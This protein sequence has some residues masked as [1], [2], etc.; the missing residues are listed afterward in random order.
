MT[1][2][3]IGLKDACPE[4]N[5]IQKT[6]GDIRYVDNISTI[7][8]ANESSL[9]WARSIDAKT[10][11]ALNNTKASHAI[12]P[13]GLDM[14]LL[15]N[16]R[17]TIL[18]S[19]YPKLHFSKLANKYFVN[20][21]IPIVHKTASI[22]KHAVMGDDVSIGAN[23]VIGKCMIGRNVVI[24]PNVSINN[25]VVIENNVRIGAGTVIGYDG[26]GYTREDDGRAVKFPH[27]GAVVIEDDVEIG[28]NVCIDRGGLMDTVLKK[29][30]KIDNLVHIAHNVIIGENA[31]VIA[32]AMVAGSVEIGRNTW[33]GPSAS[34]M[35]NT[36]IGNN[37]LVG[38]GAVTLKDIP[39]NEIWA[40]VPAK[41]L[42]DVK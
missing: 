40:G 28:N 11:E 3:T 12:V 26:F 38:M 21:E 2:T 34:I 32:G 33:I 25:N 20:V 30:C 13:E 10:I 41:K 27:V 5:V 19:N 4:L 7:E 8:D 35:N 18:S 36:E 16:K 9:V 23:T 17:I 29:G 37:V 14:K 6:K 15:S 24:G 1:V 42:K 22:D 39:D 31:F